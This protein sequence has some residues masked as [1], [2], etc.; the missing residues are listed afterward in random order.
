MADVAQPASLRE[1]NVYTWHIPLFLL[2]N[3]TQLACFCVPIIPICGVQLSAKKKRSSTMILHLHLCWFLT[4][5]SDS[6]YPGKTHQPHSSISSLHRIP[7]YR[8]KGD[9]RWHPWALVQPEYFGLSTAF[10]MSFMYDRLQY[11]EGKKE[12]YGRSD[13]SSPGG[14]TSN[15][16]TERGESNGL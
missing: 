8:T 7:L 3:P 5:L 11:W 9:S 2:N 10:K 6:V 1:E 4:L 12:D 15:L 13:F 16:G 14:L